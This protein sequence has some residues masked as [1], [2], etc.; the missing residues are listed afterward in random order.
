[1]FDFSKTKKLKPPAPLFTE[2]KHIPRLAYTFS[3]SRNRYFATT[4]TKHSSKS[5]SSASSK[6]PQGLIDPQLQQGAMTSSAP[7]H[8]TSEHTASVTDRHS[9]SMPTSNSERDESESDDMDAEMEDDVTEDDQ[10]ATQVNAPAQAIASVGNLATMHGD[11]GN[12]YAGYLS[13]TAIRH[14]LT[15]NNDDYVLITNNNTAY[16]RLVYTSMTTTPASMTPD[17]TKMV[18]DLTKKL[19]ALGNDADP[20]MADLASML[21]SAVWSLHHQ[22]DNLFDA[23]FNSLKPHKDDRTMKATERINVI[24]HILYTYKKHVVDLMEGRVDAVTKFAAAPKGIARCKQ[25]YKPNNSGRAV[26]HKKMQA[27]LKSHGMTM[28]DLRDDDNQ[29]V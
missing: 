19:N 3:T 16:V 20:F 13:H 14:R 24:C 7:S 12:L 26:N 25:G 15:I 17:Q 1:L 4:M 2:P 10:N 9:T 21:V 29:H 27:F 8:I 11:S 18:A 5:K 23:Q 28:K 6:I 22:G